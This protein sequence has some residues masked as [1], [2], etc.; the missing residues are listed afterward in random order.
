VFLNDG[1]IVDEMTEPTSE[2]VL[3]RLKA[4]GE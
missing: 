1:K 2:R 4:F 3:D